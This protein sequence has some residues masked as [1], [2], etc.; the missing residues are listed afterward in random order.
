MEQG[1]CCV[2]PDEVLLALCR[3][4]QQ[5]INTARNI[6]S[7]ALPS[8]QA[9]SEDQSPE[10]RDRI[11]DEFNTLA[12]IYQQPSSTFVDQSA[13]PIPELQNGLLA[14]FYTT[15]LPCLLPSYLYLEHA[16]Y[17]SFF[18]SN[19]FLMDEKML[20]T[21]SYLVLGNKLEKSLLRTVDTILE[22]SS[23]AHAFSSY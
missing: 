10:M 9:F 3:L 8:I 4:L 5:D 14:S 13:I 19:I 12:V 1:L 20:A 17:F 15:S 23:K 11:F 16:L 6:L 18:W 22:I 7:P 21:S 2:C